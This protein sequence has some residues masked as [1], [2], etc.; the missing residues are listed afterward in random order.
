MMKTLMKIAF[1]GAALA[2][3]LLG[4]LVIVRSQNEAA[5]IEAADEGL[6]LAETMTVSTG[7]LTITL[8]AA[9]SL[10]PGALETLSFGATAP[11]VEVLVEAGDTVKAGD[12]LAALDTADVEMSIRQS[13]LSVAQRQLS[14]DTLLTPADEIEIQLAEAQVALANAQLYS[15]STQS[16]SSPEALEIARLEEELARNSLWQAQVNRDVR[17]AQEDA[18]SDVTWL[19]QQ[20]FDSSVNSAENSVEIASLELQ[21]ALT[22]DG[23]S[24]SLASANASLVQAERNLESLLNGADAD[25]IRSAEIAVERAQLNLASAEELLENY[26][27]IAPFDGIVAEENLTVGTLP[28]AGAITLFNPATYTVD[29]SVAEADVVDLSVG[30]LVTLTLQA[31][32][33]A[34]IE[35]TVTALDV[36]SS[37]SGSLVT[38]TAQV[39]V[40]STPDLVLRPSMSAVATIT[41]EAYENVILVP[42][43]FIGTDA[44]T[45][46]AT[47]TI[48]TGQDS[49]TT[50]PVELG[51]R[52]SDSTQIISGVSVGQ[53]LALL[54]SE[55]EAT[56]TQQGGLGLGIL[57][58][59]PQGGN[60][61]GG[62]PAGFSPPS[63]GG[64]GGQRGGG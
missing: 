63:G 34:T 33:D 4:G 38:Y 15:A 61:Q 17:V 48:Q 36:V 26:V 60:F 46:G 58:G 49:Y 56:T 21:D 20:Q 42:N 19:E 62:P 2:V 50:A 29:L 25:E 28:S 7:T 40:Q 31:L 5:T 16:Q 24:S 57:G 27:L 3:I 39:T 11:V 14:L 23:S 53:T 35:G 18:R 44:T 12:V 47:V 13:Q 59:A 1:T 55:E 32:S 64:T 51:A 8:D 43:R 6:T 37:S 22:D 54:V 10:E 41:I 52:S 45:G 30:Q 9:G